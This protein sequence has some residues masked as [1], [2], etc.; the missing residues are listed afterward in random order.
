[1]YSTFVVK[2]IQMQGADF[3]LIAN[4]SNMSNV[5][6]KSIAVTTAFFGA[7]WAA[8]WTRALLSPGTLPGSSTASKLHNREA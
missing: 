5:L 3:P 6:R 8:G 4:N 1:M 2:Q 7:A